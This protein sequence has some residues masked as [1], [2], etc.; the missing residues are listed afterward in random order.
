MQYTKIRY[1]FYGHNC[2]VKLR[3]GQEIPF[4]LLNQTSPL[5]IK[6]VYKCVIGN[7]RFNLTI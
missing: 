2:L 6:I 1:A 7:K 3:K 5:V 4:F